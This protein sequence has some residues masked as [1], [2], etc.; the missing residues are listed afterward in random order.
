MIA[1]LD[2]EITPHLKDQHLEIFI[3]FVD[4]WKWLSYLNKDW[5]WWWWS[6]TAWWANKICDK[7]NILWHKYED[8]IEQYEKLRL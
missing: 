1:I 3:N 4:D 5:K 2:K 7:C 8:E 6:K